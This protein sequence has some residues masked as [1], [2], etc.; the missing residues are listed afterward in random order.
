VAEVALVAI[1]A[2]AGL[3]GALIG[4]FVTDRVER[5]RQKHEQELERE[6]REHEDAVREQADRAIARGLARVLAEELLRAA[7][8]ARAERNEGVWIRGIRVSAAPGLAASDRQQLFRY[9]LHDEFEDVLNAQSSVGALAYLR[10]F[11][12]EGSEKP[13]YSMEDAPL[14]DE[15]IEAAERGVNALA[16]LSS[17]A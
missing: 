5:T 12:F 13:P 10:D 9:L 3:L 4:G 7:A 16:R 11:V 14:V 8:H 2:G 1:S 15:A 6:R 17:Q